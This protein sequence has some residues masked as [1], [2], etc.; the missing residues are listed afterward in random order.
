MKPKG[1]RLM[2]KD[3]FEQ[4]DCTYCKKL[5]LC[6][7]VC[8]ENSSQTICTECGNVLLSLERSAN[9]DHPQQPRR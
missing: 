4:G 7:L 8:N 3:Q 1:S 9:N 5:V 2:N 6:H